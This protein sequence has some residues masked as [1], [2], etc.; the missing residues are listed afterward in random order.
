M[1]VT[2]QMAA[3]MSAQLTTLSLNFGVKPSSSTQ[4]TGVVPIL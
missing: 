3:Q 2:Q 4:I 1:V